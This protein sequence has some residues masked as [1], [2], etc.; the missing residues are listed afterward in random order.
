MIV[1]IIMISLMIM[2][3]NVMMMMMTI[4]VMTTLAVGSNRNP[5][6][7]FRYFDF[8]RYTEQVSTRGWRVRI[9]LSLSLAVAEYLYFLFTQK[10]DI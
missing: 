8:D 9:F 5:Q 10:L 4:M 6:K 3:V 1:M 7:Y 2:I